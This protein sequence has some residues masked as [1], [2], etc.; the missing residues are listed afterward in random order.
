MILIKGVHLEVIFL[1]NQIKEDANRI[2]AS[3]K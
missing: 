1:L 3:L 2:L